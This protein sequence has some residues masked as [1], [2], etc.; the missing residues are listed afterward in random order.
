MIG[1]KFAYFLAVFTVMSFG[2]GRDATIIDRLN[3]L[4]AGQEKLEQELMTGE[5]ELKAGQQELKTELKTDKE[6]LQEKV[7]Q[8]SDAVNFL[9]H[10]NLTDLLGVG[11]K[12]EDVKEKID[13]VLFQITE[14]GG[15][16][17]LG[18]GLRL[19]KNQGRPDA[20]SYENIDRLPKYAYH[21]NGMGLDKEAYWA[22]Y[23][24]QFPALL[25]MHFQKS[26]RLAKIGF[27]TVFPE[28]APK[29]IRFIGSDDFPNGQLYWKLETRESLKRML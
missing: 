15:N 16:G 19:I 27:S 6:K 14:T 23:Q 10:A 11:D 12:L 2:C 4:Q 26:Y 25:W 7:D 28:D 17:T 8:I 18:H 22:N 1:A 21:R 5:E 9:A 3:Q 20:S 29:I 24:G 13:E